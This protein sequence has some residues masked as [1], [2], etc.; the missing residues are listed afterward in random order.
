ML[1]SL[2]SSLMRFL[3]RSWV[4]CARICIVSRRSRM[5]SYLQ[6]SQD[7]HD[8]ESQSIQ[9]CLSRLG[10]CCRGQCQGVTSNLECPPLSIFSL[11]SD[12]APRVVLSSLRSSKSESAALAFLCRLMSESTLQCP[13][14]RCHDLIHIS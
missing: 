4:F 6:I 12:H 3:V 5:S 10:L 1:D 7:I 2:R 8:I 11:T 13:S 9:K 14:F